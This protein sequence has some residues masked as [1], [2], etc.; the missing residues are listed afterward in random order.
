MRFGK[1]PDD[2]HDGRILELPLEFVVE[3]GESSIDTRGPQ[4]AKRC[5]CSLVETIAQENSR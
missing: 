1:K 2:E 4:A 5:R 3:T